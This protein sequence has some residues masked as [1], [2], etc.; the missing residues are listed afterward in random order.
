MN[1]LPMEVAST[2]LERLTPLYHLAA[3]LSCRTF[4]RAPPLKTRYYY[5]Y[6][7]TRDEQ[8]LRLKFFIWAHR[9]GYS[10]CES[11]ISNA[12]DKGCPDIA[13]YILKDSQLLKGSETFK[14]PLD[15]FY[16]N[17]FRLYNS[18]QGLF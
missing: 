9:M 11:T 7:Y 12:M 14:A 10:W 15:L 18:H 6:R 5:H 2:I 4:S 16:Y 8:R 1:S 17:N 13:W 3:R